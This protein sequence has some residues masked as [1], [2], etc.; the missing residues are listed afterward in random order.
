MQT[1]AALQLQSFGSA[2]DE[3]SLKQLTLNGTGINSGGR[4]WK[5]ISVS[6]PAEEIARGVAAVLVRE[7]IYADRHGNPVDFTRT[8]WPGDTTRLVVDG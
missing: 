6:V 3:A 8:V 4:K 5:L 7:D 1:G 2:I